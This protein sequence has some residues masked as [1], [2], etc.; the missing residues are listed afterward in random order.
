MEKQKVDYIIEQY[1][2]PIYGFSIRK[3]K[4]MEKAEELAS[5]ILIQVYTTLLKKEDILD[6]NSYIFKIAHNGWARYCKENFE[7]NSYVVLEENFAAYEYSLET[8]ILQSEEY[9][10]LRREIAFLNQQRRNIIKSY[11]YEGRKIEEIAKEQKIPAGTVKWHLFEAKKELKKGMDKIR[12]IGNLG[13]NPITFKSTGH[14]GRPGEKGDTS[15]FLSKRLSQNIIYSCYYRPLS[16]IEISSELGVSPIFIEDEVKELS[17]YGFMDLLANGKYQS[18][19]IIEESA[20]TPQVIEVFEK[21]ADII[22][23]EYFLEL[24]KLK[25][26]IEKLPF[27]YTNKDFNFLMWSLII[28]ASI[29][30][31]FEELEEIDFEEVSVIRKDGGNYIAYAWKDDIWNFDN[32]T[33]SCS[34]MERRTEIAEKKIRGVKSQV[35]WSG[36]K[37]NWKDTIMSDYIYLYHFINGKLPKNDVNLEQYERLI[38]KGY[39]IKEGEEYKANIVYFPDLETKEALDKLLPRKDDTIFEIAKELDKITFDLKKTGQP[40]HMHKAIKYSNQNCLQYKMPI[41]VMKKLI[42]RKLLRVPEEPYRKGIC[43]ILFY[44]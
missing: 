4:S 27:Y 12:S 37:T 17:D 9:G 21:Y 5:L 15:Y 30:L 22:I 18:N 35:Y 25:S 11:Y 40:E 3:T 6:I 10:I 42:D 14:S 31:R 24:F 32:W 39:L 2:K 29:Q 19:I 7:K 13:L 28:Y 20:Y 43:N 26:E 33:K 1:M 36:E 41:F 8:K 23:D 34:Y 44:E 16:V 38:Q